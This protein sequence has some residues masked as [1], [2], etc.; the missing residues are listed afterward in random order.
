MLYRE[1]NW[2]GQKPARAGRPCYEE[3]PDMDRMDEVDGMD[4]V[5]EWAQ[6]TGQVYQLFCYDP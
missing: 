5:D 6:A 4:G 1:R 3:S 2:G